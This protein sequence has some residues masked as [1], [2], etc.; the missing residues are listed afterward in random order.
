MSSEAAGGIVMLVAALAALV[1]ANAGLGDSYQELWDTRLS[2]ELGDVLHLDHLTLRDWVNDL[3]MVFFFF[4]VGLEIKRELVAGE[5]RDRRA[6]AMPVLAALGGVVVPALIY[7]AFNAGHEGSRG[8][9]IP[10]ATDIAFAVGILSLVGRRVP[11]GAKIFL[12]GLAIADDLVAIVVI[13]VFYTEALSFGWLAVAVGAV[14]AAVAL[15][16]LEIVAIVPYTALAAVCWL[17]LLESGVHATLAGV[18]FAFLTP[19]R[20][21]QDPR[22]FPE[23][24]RTM[25][26]DY[27]NSLREG[28]TEEE[29]EHNDALLREL[30]RLASQNESPLERIESRLTDWVT[31]GVVPVFAFANAGVELS[32]DVLADSLGDRV[33]LGVA[34]GLLVGKTVGVLGASWLATVLGLGRLPE[35]TSWRHMLGLAV[36][37]GIGFTVALFVAGLSFTEP[38]L[39]DSAKIGILSASLVAGILGF[40]LLRTGPL[41][42]SGAEA[43]D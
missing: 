3:L 17:G 13:A 22:E 14:M 6:A 33:V 7:V 12:L 37:A 2:I 23:H 24:A 16:R 30:Q 28:V 15:R 38:E 10:M 18:A 4:L 39:T 20:P 9:G 21:F 11:F 43:E 40:V 41:P 8:W 29:L 34:I 19:T 32:G 36:T 25:V 31:F 42:A 27:E 1:W 26:G 35:G 5:L